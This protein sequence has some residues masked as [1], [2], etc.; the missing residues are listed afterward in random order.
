MATDLTNTNS[1]PS[2]VSISV[3]TAWETITLPI[4]C[5]Q[6]D[7]YAAVELKFD[8]AATP[9]I[10]APIDAATWFTVYH[11]NRNIQS[12]DKTF[13]LKAASSTTVYL[14]ML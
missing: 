10:E 7:V 13:S 5:S 9:T 6:C 12:E 4:G 1:Y 3:G 2:L 8:Y 11:S 14:R